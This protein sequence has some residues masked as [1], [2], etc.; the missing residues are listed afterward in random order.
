MAK[1]TLKIMNEP[2]K[3]KNITENENGMAIVFT[4]GM[5]TLFLLLALAFITTSI[6]EKKAA[7]NYNSLQIAR[8]VVQS[9]VHRAMATLDFYA[10]DKTE[11]LTN[12]YS[13]NANGDH[14]GLEEL[15]ETQVDGITYYSSGD[16]VLANGP[17][18]Q[19]LPED[20]GADTPI[21]SRLAYMV[22]SDLGKLDISACLDSGVNA[23]LLKNL[24]LYKN[25]SVT[26]SNSAN[27]IDGVECTSI[28]VS[29]N[30]ARE[31]YGK[32][33]VGRPGRR[34]NELFLRC[35]NDDHSWFTDND[36]KKISPKIANP[37]G[38]LEPTGSR[39]PD[40]D[41]I[42]D[43]LTINNDDIKDSFKTFFVVDNLADAEAFWINDDNGGGVLIKENDELFHRFNLMRSNWDGATVDSFSSSAPRLFSSSLE[44][45]N[46]SIPWLVDWKFEGGFG[47]GN[48]DTCRN[49]IIAN[50]IDYNDTNDTAVT[51]YPGN[52]PP[53]YVG[54][55]KIPYINEIRLK[56]EGSVIETENAEDTESSDYTCTVEIKEAKLELVNMYDYPPS[57]T[58]DS[59]II[60]ISGEYAWTPSP[61]GD[62]DT[63]PKTF[64]DAEITITSFTTGNYPTSTY[65]IATA[66]QLE[67]IAGNLN[68]GDETGLSRS[69]TDFK[70]T[71]LTV[72]LT[73]D[74]DEL[75]DFANI[76]NVDTPTSGE[77]LISTVTSV[78][79][80]VSGELYFDG[81]VADPRQ[82][83]LSV[84]WADSEFSSNSAIPVDG[85]GIGIK[86]IGCDPSVG[87]NTDSE[88]SD[89][90]P[91]QLSTAYIRNA[92]M[93]SPWELGL[94]HRGKAWQTINL[95]KYN[96]TEGMTGG[97]NNYSDGDAN[98]LDQIKMNSS[99][100]VYGKINI[101]SNINEILK[102]LFEK[103]RVGS[104]ITSTEGP[105]TLLQANG[106][107]AYEIDSTRASNLADKVLDINGTNK[108]SVFY[109]RAQILRSTDGLPEL[110]NNDLFSTTQV[111]IT[112]AA[113]EE[114]I[115]KFINL[116]KAT[117]TANSYTVIVVAQTIKDIG[118]AT[119]NAD[120]NND[121]T[122]DKQV[123]TTT[124]TYD[125]DGDQILATQKIL[126]IVQRN[127]LTNKF[128]ISYL[129]YLSE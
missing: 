68:E 63:A 61:Y 97:G 28:Y 15:L 56:I 83:L 43:E 77:D 99:T 79:S 6:V 114:I 23:S 48:A 33:V 54:L 62:E 119:L 67:T 86:N 37:N 36:A 32:P 101:N 75:Y 4:I 42:F 102:V 12:V 14:D 123:S 103:I 116:T 92:P 94:I 64:Q 40:F 78:D 55:E 81:Q 16:Y 109:T 74:L 50:L 113:Q 89:P 122:V 3:K 124:G 128:W 87:G 93:Q 76:V 10:A 111:Q 117:S 96:S 95:K 115:G 72:K 31:P 66:I 11:N 39:W 8:M 69:I 49:Q 7:Q 34:M 53:T 88:P 84:D 17:H 24:D 127:P 41:T 21:V 82:N 26:E 121:G 73:N 106:S 65:S 18:W 100:E 71:N 20:H 27:A 58:I 129:L 5:I 2:E 120:T 98:I 118:G 9:G 35:I 90:E 126:A 59:A 104:D 13:Y 44:N 22:I 80:S 46:F 60:S 51:D 125:E 70:I 52:N 91:W 107:N 85:G 29:Y 1:R 105:G 45:D 110:W 38:T 47:A 19:Y 112:D 30:S 108:G 57:V 25:K